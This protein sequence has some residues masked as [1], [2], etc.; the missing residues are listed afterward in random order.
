MTCSESGN[1]FLSIILTVLVVS[2]I[3]TSNLLRPPKAPLTPL[4]ILW[5]KSINATAPVSVFF[6]SSNLFKINF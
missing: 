4:N 3:K 5:R 1:G 6:N 2:S